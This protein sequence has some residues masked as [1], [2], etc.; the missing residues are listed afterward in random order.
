MMALLDSSWHC[1][2]LDASPQAVHECI[3]RGLK[4]VVV[5]DIHRIDL[6]S[7][8]MDVALCLDVLYHEKVDDLRA[9][10]EIARIVRPGGRLILNVA[11]WKALRGSHDKVVCGARR[12]T[13]DQLMELATRCGF[14]VEKLH[15][16]NAILSPL[17]LLWRHA[18]RLIGRSGSDLFRLPSPLNRCLSTVAWWDALACSRW[19]LIWGGSLFGVFRKLDSQAESCERDTATS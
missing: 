5:G 17:I 3:N 19:G 12:Y 15:A 6:E 8:S 13:P 7:A 1:T 16:W 11:A 14:V 18:G 2:G 9:M 10:L 4:N